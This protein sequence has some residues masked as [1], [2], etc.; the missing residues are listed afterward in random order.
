MENLD[1]W[2]R[3]CFWDHGRFSRL[4]HE[5][6]NKALNTPRGTGWKTVVDAFDALV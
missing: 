3:R 6:D 2:L 1:D 5:F 4:G